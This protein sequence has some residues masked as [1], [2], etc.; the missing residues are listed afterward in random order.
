[1][2][3]TLQFILSVIYMAINTTQTLIISYKGHL[4][5]VEPFVLGASK[6]GFL[7]LR[8]YQVQGYSES[9]KPEGWKLFRVEEIQSV[10]LQEKAF[11]PEDRTDYNPQDK[12]LAHR[13]AF[14]QKTETPQT[15]TPG[16]KFS[17]G[18]IYMTPGA[19]EV[20][21]RLKIDPIVLISRHV[22]GDWGDLGEED[23]K[24]NELSL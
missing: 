21:T 5:E 15:L 3:Q 24:E 9:E 17:L 4:R 19:S 16:R 6:S 8:A 22:S 14:V 18:R 23:K 2:T 7:Y 13:L 20:F 11:F 12:L 10:I 1:M